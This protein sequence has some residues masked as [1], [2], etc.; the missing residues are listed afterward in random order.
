MVKNKENKAV[1]RSSFMVADFETL[2]L[3]SETEQRHV[4]YAVGVMKV[5][6]GEGPRGE[7]AWWYSEDYT[8]S[9]FEDRSKEKV[10]KF[11]LYLSTQVTK[12]RFVIYFHTF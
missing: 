11:I 2:V 7:I 6:P 10:T 5:Y 4:P 12:K 1:V 8:Q 9:D 3:S